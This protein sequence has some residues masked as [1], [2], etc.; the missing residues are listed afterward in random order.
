[1]TTLT[2]EIDTSKISGASDINMVIYSQLPNTNVNIG[3]ISEVVPSNNR[4]PKLSI[5]G[6]MNVSFTLGMNR[7]IKK[8][9]K[10]HNQDFGTISNLVIN[11]QLSWESLINHKNVREYIVQTQVHNIGFCD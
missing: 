2:I 7:I 6:N 5:L 8:D 9:W 3:N 4:S 11:K 10:N 1:M